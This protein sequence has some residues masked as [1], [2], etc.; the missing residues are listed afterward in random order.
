M[1]NGLN[2]MNIGEYNIIWFI[3]NFHR[4]YVR[5]TQS[6]RIIVLNMIVY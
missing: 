3:K 1:N 6:T 2:L 5:R 4:L